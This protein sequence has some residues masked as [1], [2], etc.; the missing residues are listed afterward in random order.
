MHSGSRSPP[1]AEPKGSPR[2]SRIIRWI[3]VS[4]ALVLVV[5]VVGAILYYGYTTKPGWV[6]VSGKK[7]WDYLDL[8]IVPAALAL[9][10]TWL[11]WEQSRREREAENAQKEREE[12]AEEARK[13]REQE[14]ENQRAQDEALQ[15]YLDQMSK[16]LIDKERP[17]R[18]THAGDNL[19]V[20]ARARTLT[21]LQKLGP[22]RKRSTL[23]FLYESGLIARELVV[24]LVDADLSGAELSEVNLSEAYLVGAYL[25]GANLSMAYL[26]KAYL[27]GT[28]LSGANLSGANLSGAYLRGANVSAANLSGTW[29]QG[30]DLNGADLREADL[31]GAYLGDADLRD[32]YLSR[33]HLSGA[34]LSGADLRGAYLGDTEGLSREHLEQAPLVNGATMPKIQEDRGADGEST[35]P[36]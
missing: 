29:M 25:V 30:A 31:R 8:L 4:G 20:V 18:R 21:V 2:S 32:A 16:L 11:N 14:L 35:G 15:A 26:R 28:N 1:A 27:S 13:T 6:G 5:E 7:F 10:V 34:D 19:S 22:E 3:L 9:G 36:R 17:L 12:V 24:S 33:A 23:H